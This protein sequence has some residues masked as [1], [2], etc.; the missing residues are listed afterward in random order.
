MREITVRVGSVRRSVDWKW[1]SPENIFQVCL[2][3]IMKSIAVSIQAWHFENILK[4]I[5][6]RFAH[7]SHHFLFFYDSAWMCWWT[8][9]RILLPICQ[10]GNTTSIRK[11]RSVARTSAGRHFC[12]SW[13]GSCVK[14]EAAR[15]QHLRDMLLDS[16]RR[17]EKFPFLL[18]AYL[19]LRLSLQ[20]EPA[21]EPM[22][23]VQE[24]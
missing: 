11:L 5:Q 22:P 23:A 3:C 10:N 9:T 2:R 12:I 21:K 20:V 8:K 17:T 14:V 24:R 19:L 13:G 6:K 1:F 7:L 15:E 4:V 18:P 16:T